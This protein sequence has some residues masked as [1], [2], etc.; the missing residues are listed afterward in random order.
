MLAERRVW[1]EALLPA[2][3][4][5]ERFG[6]GAPTAMPAGPVRDCVLRYTQMDAFWSAANSGIAPV[7]LGRTG[8]WKTYGAWLVARFAHWQLLPAKVVECGP[9][10]TELDAQF[11]REGG[12]RPYREA[13]EVPFL[14]LDDFTQVKSGSRAAEL[15][16]NL[17]G[18]RF[19]ARLPTMFTGNYTQVRGSRDLGTVA[20]D[21][22]ADFAR[23]LWH[24]S[25]GYFVG[26]V[27]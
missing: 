18:E 7:F 1:H 10:F 11:Y 20:R 22:R 5:P 17:V 23:R 19:S 13:A 14:V 15:M 6:G 9:F 26:G 12:L 4:I 24:G 25:T 21:Y 8:T 2:L 3:E 27:E 16:A